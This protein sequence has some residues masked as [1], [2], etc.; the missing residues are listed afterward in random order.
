MNL[1]LIYESEVDLFLVTSIQLHL[2]QRLYCITRIEQ[3][4]L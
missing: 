2:L 4:K 1:K 3:T